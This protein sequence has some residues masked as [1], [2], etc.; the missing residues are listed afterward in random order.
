MKKTFVVLEQGC[1]PNY[2][3]T[4]KHK[5]QFNTDFSDCFR[6]N[7]K[8][9]TNDK[10]ADFFKKD[11]C[12]SEGRSYLYEQVKGKYDYY[13]FIDDDINIKSN[14]DLE[15]ANEIKKLLEKY[16]P[17]HG[18][19]VNDSWPRFKGINH[20]VF[21][22]KSGDLCV[23]LFSENYADLVFPTW[24]HGSAGSM[25]YAQFLAYIICPTR[26]IYLNSV[27]AKNT[28]HAVHEDCKHNQFSNKNEVCSN[29]FDI[30]KTNKHKH[31]FKKWA[32]QPE[33]KDR[34]HIN[35]ENMNFNI[36]NEKIIN[37]IKV[38]ENKK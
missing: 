24:W 20:E 14:T 9:D 22:F 10:N 7:W 30:L 5:Q 38:I 18:S 2:P 19:I 1:E 23:Q 3:L 33:M 27:D 35:S 8:A 15:P 28:R 25:F 11:I 36:T 29:F 34:V 12:W 37:I 13:I 4:A 26:S 16:K 21:Q 31:I 32:S 17:I 6:L